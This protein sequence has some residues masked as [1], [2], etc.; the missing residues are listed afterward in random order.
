MFNSHKNSTSSY[1][2]SPHFSDGGFKVKLP[3]VLQPGN[4]EPGL[5]Q[6]TGFQRPCSQP[7]VTFLITCGPAGL[8]THPQR[9]PGDVLDLRKLLDSRNLG[10]VEPNYTL[11]T[12]LKK[13]KPASIIILLTD[14]IPS[15]LSSP[16][17]SHR[18]AVITVQ[19]NTNVISLYCTSETNITHIKSC[20]TYT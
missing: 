2:S 1:S 5:T 6:T 13:K 15:H 4:S 3:Q 12:V 10:T 19:D 11:A 7:H 16:I 8:A 18:S 14:C 20:T 17:L 9:H